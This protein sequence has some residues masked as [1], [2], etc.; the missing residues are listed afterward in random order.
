[1]WLVSFVLMHLLSN[2]SLYLFP[3]PIQ[4]LEFD[5]L[6]QYLLSAGD[7]N[8]NIFHNVVGYRAQIID[9]EEKRRVATGQTHKERLQQ[10]IDDAR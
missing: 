2:I 10:Q 4:C 8:I 1:M 3:V 6:G 5:T 7:K 9:F